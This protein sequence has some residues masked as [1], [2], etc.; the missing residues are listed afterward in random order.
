MAEPGAFL[1]C[2]YCNTPH[3]LAFDA[4]VYAPWA[5]STEV[6]EADV[7]RIREL[8]AL[9]RRDEAKAI[10]RAATACSHA[11][12]EAAIAAWGAQLAQS[13]MMKG[14]LNGIG[15]AASALAWGLLAA[16][17][18]ALVGVVGEV[19]AGVAVGMM[20][21]GGVVALV[22]LT[23]LIGTVRYLGGA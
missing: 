18:L 14:Q 5:E 20:A 9:G 12:A 17:I 15:W 22:F 1:L 7:A 6:G 10:Y 8:I 3:R 13:L 2:V 16:G 4:A 21:V 19:P 11:D 23:A